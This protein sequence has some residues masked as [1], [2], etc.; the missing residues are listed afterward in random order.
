VVFALIPAGW[1]AA[2]FGEG[3]V[4]G[5]F[6]GV[7][8][9]PGDLGRWVGGVAELAGCQLHPPPGEV[10][11]WWLADVLGEPAGQGGPGDVHPA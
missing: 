2:V 1:G 11:V 3:P 6:G 5:V 7:A 8:D 10:A 9:G 4:E